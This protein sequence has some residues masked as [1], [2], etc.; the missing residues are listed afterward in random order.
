[1]SQFKNINIFQFKEPYKSKIVLWAFLCVF[2]PVGLYLTATIGSFLYNAVLNQEYF[3][4]FFSFNQNPNPQNMQNFWSFFMP[5]YIV[6]M[7]MEYVC[8]IVLY[9]LIFRLDYYKNKSRLDLGGY[10]VAPLNRRLLAR[11]FDVSLYHM[12][13]L[14]PCGLILSQKTIDLHNE[15]IR[16]MIMTIFGH[17]SLPHVG[18][19]SLGL[20]NLLLEG[21]TGRTIGKFIVGIKVIKNDG[22]K[23]NLW[24]SIVRTFLKFVDVILWGVIGYVLMVVSPAN[25]RCGDRVAKTVVVV[26]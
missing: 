23:I 12:V 3:K 6:I 10:Q 7:A 1:M 18:V 2:I 13:I 8:L 14:V 25:Q 24:G 20:V 9:A 26:Q 16:E 17:M 4:T 19:V 15:E 11:F 5:Y 22:S 21:F